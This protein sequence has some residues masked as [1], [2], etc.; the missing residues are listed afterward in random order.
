MKF[1]SPCM[2]EH[3]FLATSSRRERWLD[4]ILR[5]VAKAE[6]RRRPHDDLA[7]DTHRTSG[8]TGSG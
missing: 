1:F 6:E 3:A 4:T 8:K 2:Q 5:R 7:Q